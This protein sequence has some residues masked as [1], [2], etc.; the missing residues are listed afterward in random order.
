MQK[1]NWYYMY[2]QFKRIR[3]GDFFCHEKYYLQPYN[4]LV[5]LYFFFIFFSWK[6]IFPAPQ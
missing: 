6:I 1:M 5:F 4:F 2:V 3:T